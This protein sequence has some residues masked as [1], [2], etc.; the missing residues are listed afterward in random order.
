M[1]PVQSTTQSRRRFIKSSAAALTAAACGPSTPEAQ[2]PTV[3]SAE[4]SA[5][6]SAE[7]GPAP[8][9]A[10]SGGPAASGAPATGK[11]PATGGAG[12]TPLQASKMLEELAKAGVDVTKTPDL[13]K[14]PLD[15]K[16]KV[17]PLLQKAMGM[18]SCTG[19]HKEG[20]MK[21]PTRNKAISAAMWK[22][23]VGA[24]RD[25]KGG[26]IFCDSCHAGKVKVLGRGDKEALKKFMQ[27]D[28]EGKLT[29]ADKKEHA[30]TGC[31][32]ETMEGKIIATLWKI[33]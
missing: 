1:I 6:P 15:K 11:A 12:S 8:S 17:M 2:T 9:A 7:P 30:C 25:D 24:L 5:P 21:A 27:T 22:N 3:P 13:T 28:Y 20:D 10:P 31:H 33:D 16:K 19:C 4:P 32:G 26:P 23:F 14:L 18:E 29:R